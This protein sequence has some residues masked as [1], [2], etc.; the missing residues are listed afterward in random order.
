MNEIQ[1]FNN[2]DFGDIRTV[3]ID[4]EIWLVGNDVAAALGYAKPYNAVQRHVDEDDTLIQGVVDS[5][6]QTQQTKVINES[7]LYSLIIMSNLPSA[8]KFKKWVTSEVLPSVRKTGAYSGKINTA[9]LSPQT[10]V[11]TQMCKVIALTELR[12]AETEKRTDALEKQTADNTRSIE[13]IRD[14]FAQQ[15]DNWRKFQHNLFTTAVNNS[16]DKD[17]RA[18]RVE[19]YNLLEERANCDLD[20]RQKNMRR[21]LRERGATKT[22][23]DQ[24]TKIDVIEEDK[25]LREIYT[26]IV[27]ELCIRYSI[28][29]A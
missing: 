10:Q 18:L 12:I 15:G 13:V 28:A 17:F 4:G 16:P 9:A 6:G 5:R 27:K 14:T 3:E 29:T 1:V 8:K 20:T 22:K 2:P 11:L 19:S 25:R 23:I 7:G 26:T 21:R 24:V